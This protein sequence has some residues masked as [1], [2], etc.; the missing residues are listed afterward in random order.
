MK[1]VPNRYWAVDLAKA[2]CRVVSELVPIGKPVT[3]LLE[4]LGLWPFGCA[5]GCVAH[6][7]YASAQRFMALAAVRHT[8]RA[9]VRAPLT[10][11]QHAS[12]LEANVETWA[13]LKIPLRVAT[14]PCIAKASARNQQAELAPRETFADIHGLHNHAL[15]RC[16][17]AARANIG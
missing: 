12:E 2:N 1:S 13:L 8:A 10:A 9:W 4:W 17:E 11:R 15:A 6:R 5:K 7:L 16:C 3:P 14:L